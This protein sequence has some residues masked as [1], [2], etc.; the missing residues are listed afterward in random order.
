MDGRSGG[1]ALQ[2]ELKSRKNLERLTVPT[3]LIPFGAQQITP[4]M[5]PLVTL[6]PEH[7]EIVA[8][9]VPGGASN[10]QDI[11]P[12]TS[13]Q[14]GL[15]FH[16]MM[17]E[18]RDSYVV[19]SLLEFESHTHL[20]S[21]I[22]ALQYV[23]DR[24]DI[25]RT[26]FFWEKLP[27]PVQVVCRQATLTV[28][29]LQL[30]RARDSL[31]QLKERIRPD[32]NTLQ[33]QR[34]PLMRLEVAADGQ[35]ARWY[36]LLTLHHLVCDGHSLEVVAREVKAHI[37]G[38][39]HTLPEPMQYRK[40]V[41]QT[42]AKARAHDAEAFFRDKFGK[43]DEPTAPFGLIGAYGVAH[44]VET[45]SQTLDLEL[46]RRLR[47]QAR[48]QRVSPATLF[49]AAW[50]L[51]IARTGGRDD[52]A[53]GTVFFGRLQM[54]GE[55]QHRV[56]LFLNT[57]P[58]R[59]QLH[60]YS[61]R[62][63]VFQMQRELLESLNH[64]QASLAIAQRCSGIS[65]SI[66]LFTT[67]LNYR[68]GKRDSELWANSTQG[69]REIATFGWT[70][71]PIT[72]SI[73]DLG[74]DFVLTAQ[75]EHRIA[76]QRTVGYLSKALQ[77]LVE[78]LERA[79]Q[80]P[81][82]E[83]PI[84]PADERHQVVETFNATQVSYPRKS[85]I[86]ELFEEQVERTPDTVA[87]IFASESLTY[88]KLS[89]KANQLAR[90]L[91]AK[92]IRPDRLVG[93]CIERS[94]EMV[95]GLLGILKAGGAYIPLDPSYPPERL[96]YMLDDATPGLLLT[97][98]SLRERLPQTDAEVIALDGQWDEI[99][100]ERTGNL[101]ARLLAL[102]SHHLAYVIYTSGSTGRPKGVMVEHTAVVNFLTSMTREPGINAEDCL[103]AV[104][105]V[106]F[107]I[108][109]LEIYLPLIRGAK[110][111]LVRREDASNG[112]LLIEM[113]EDIDVSMLQATPAT[114]KLLLGAGWNGRPALRGLCGGE[115][116]TTD[117]SGKLKSR[118]GA[119][120]NLYGPTET[121]IW[122]CCKE[123]AVTP[124]GSEPT[125][126]LGRPIS[127]TQI[128]ILDNQLQPVPVG[129]AGEI[130][131]G[132]AG[133][134]R[135]Y[136]N[137]PDL[138]AQRFINDPFGGDP[139]ARMYK[140]GDLGR[141]QADGNIEY[142]GRNDNQVKIRGYRIELTEIE[143]H[144]LQHS[145]IKEAVVIARED[146]A[147]GQRLVAYIVP[148]DGIEG[149]TAG[150]SLESVRAH[151]KATLPEYMVPSAFVMLE[152]LPLT[153]N[154]KLNR[155]A[156]PAPDL[157]AY[158]SQQYEAPQG[159]MEEILAGI[160]CDLL[161]VEQVGRHDNFF[162]LGGHSLSVLKLIG[163]V[164]EALAIQA[165]VVTIFQYPTLQ[166]MAQL[167]QRIVCSEATSPLPETAQRAELDE[168][169]I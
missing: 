81:A 157:G 53:F 64:E 56:G 85:L 32:L 44:R 164:A 155:R 45:A 49:H 144:L 27:E 151:L 58:L 158:T 141:W 153:L 67:L 98:V 69:Y 86:H 63:L 113:L 156:L 107:D 165:P 30:D 108:A 40:H 52:V 62:D 76:P 34:A 60:D 149:A 106:S 131:I 124:T 70:N 147:E 7:I 42:L 47:M 1:A 79:P 87:V 43:M 9:G 125:E 72:L 122:S 54:K 3:N 39:A 14:E 23:I 26:A 10:I 22:P 127:N 103:L 145:Q 160:W 118:V 115:S 88:A 51:V 96:Q 139:G 129:V 66:P 114:W 93:I 84:L 37:E 36:A 61:A 140:T 19:F 128:Y 134:A 33:L 100:R 11:Y 109:A 24:H 18:K 94:L 119:L 159:K 15:L 68:H 135:G 148:G 74:E 169:V 4:E 90:Y 154:G 38:R 59:L 126:S 41:A 77:S 138:T 120:W 92:G 101:N 137:R 95:I 111:A 99:A 12:L 123:I 82:L 31:E 13:L 162:D 150:P 105:T 112:H 55:T 143:A 97:Q 57:L 166:E 146:A 73:D 167:F 80:T 117:L 21:F 102:N 8:Q 48:H 78:A 29:E 116:L 2:F 132:G 152:G 130:H 46:A 104:T 75:T 65:G 163:R 16:H 110:L 142:L 168:G 161:K 136:L 83:L 20:A 121:T 133:V 17:D 35:G 5:L 25:L 6:A 71:Y 50:G 91:R 89:E 28:G